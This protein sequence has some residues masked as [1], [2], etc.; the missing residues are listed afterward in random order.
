MIDRQEIVL[1]LMLNAI[2]YSGLPAVLSPAL[3]GIGAVLMF[4]RVTAEPG[5][6]HGLNRHL[7][8]TPA[9]LDDVLGL[10]G[11]AGYEFVS[12]DDLPQRISNPDPDRPFVAITLD[13]GYR[14]NL[15]EALPVFEKHNAPFTVYVAPSLIDG[16]IALWWELA[17][18]LVTVA[19]SLTFDNG[20]SPVELDCSTPALKTLAYRVLTEH[21]TTRLAEEDQQAF[22]CTLAE[23]AGL[24]PHARS[25]K[26]LMNWDEISGI[27]SH[28]LCTIGA[29]TVGHFN[30][31]RLDGDRAR[32]ELT[33]SK[34]ILESKL[35]GPVR[36]M[37][38][39]YGYAR[40]VGE[41]EA[42][43]AVE[44]GFETAVT[45]LHGVIHG[46]HAAHLTALPRISI[47]GKYQNTAYVR[48]MLSG[49]T[50]MLASRGRRVVTLAQ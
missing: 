3:S 31:R 33:E 4:H 37:A 1:K 21:I 17:E 24:D 42:R 2:R 6:P 22:V 32:H 18:E 28:P 20:Q 26:L 15:E 38:Y 8:V 34:S 40:A 23:K 48:T 27:S 11:Q 45:T 46:E 5:L 44:C 7:S 25:R 16:R 9:F 19:Q 49:V 12:M 36:H 39:P 10:V 35:G 47:N 14:D 29:H 43:L 13:D 41:R 50:S 30:L